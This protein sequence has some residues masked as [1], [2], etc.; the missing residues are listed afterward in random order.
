MN[1][2]SPGFASFVVYLPRADLTVVVLSNVY[3]S[4]PT[5]IGNDIAAIVLG[6]PYKP[7]VIGAALTPAAL[8][9]LNSR[10]FTFGADFYQPNATLTF[11]PRGNELFLLW[12]G[13]S[14]SPMIP[15]SADHFLDRAYGEAVTIE[16]DS[17]G[18]AI[19]I[20]YGRFRGVAR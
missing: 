20:I 16:R 14:L 11:S 3:S 12:P 18:K 17:A 6:K 1:G 15:V 19:A 9:D 2:R 13:G 10:A 4:V 7:F 5:G 8:S